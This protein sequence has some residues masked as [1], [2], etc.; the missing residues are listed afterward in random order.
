M[1]LSERFNTLERLFYLL[2]TTNSIVEKRQYLKELPAEMSDDVQYVFEVLSGQHKL[3]Y[4]YVKIDTNDDLPTEFENKTIKEYLAPLNTCNLLNDWST[5]RI[6]ECCQRC[7]WFC[8][9]VEGIVNRTYKLGIGKSVL[10]K[11]GLGAM[12]GK[13]YEGQLLRG[14]IYVTEKLDGNRCIASFDGLKWN[15]TS[16]NGKP[17]KVQ[18]NMTGLP[19]EYVYDGEVMSVEQTQ[20]SIKLHRGDIGAYTD[21]SFNSTSGL[22]NSK[23]GDKSKLVYNIF[24]IMADDVPYQERR[25]VLMGIRADHVGEALDWRILPVLATYSNFDVFNKEVHNLLDYV[26]SRGGEG[27]MINTGNGYY[28]HKR[29]NELLKYKK[30]K[31]MDLSVIGITTGTGKYEGMVGALECAGYIDGKFV[32]VQ[33]GS[34][35]SDDQRLAWTLNPNAIIGKIVE[36]AYFSESQN[37]NT[38]GT[39]TYSLR[40]P[41][42]KNIRTD[43]TE[44]SLW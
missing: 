35:L 28:Q 34:G 41:R 4:T 21:A 40:F 6:I 31:T 12:L 8:D 11:D 44:V 17:M 18:F 29:S 26:T 7:R 36:I 42:L 24:D 33:V 23:Y 37:K 38:N 39:T 15:F 19:T 20:S 27:L 1:T 16:R 5:G 2:Q 30:V 9:I 3:G 32:S 13:S 22:I 25:E 10:P 14:P 43:K